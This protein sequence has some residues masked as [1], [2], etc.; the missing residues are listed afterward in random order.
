[1]LDELQREV[2]FTK[3]DVYLGYH[4]IRMREEN[5]PKTI[6]RTHDG[7]FEFSMMHFELTNALSTFEC[8]MN[9]IFVSVPIIF[10]LLFFDDILIYN[11]IL[12]KACITCWHHLKT[13]GTPT[14]ICEATKFSFGFRKW[15]ISSILYLTWASGGPT[16]TKLEI[17]WNG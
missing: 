5:N 2:F 9:S 1:M 16:L 4:Q 13:I 12:G 17:R 6:S 10:V 8:L 11:Q 14:T 7:D 15:N 3:F